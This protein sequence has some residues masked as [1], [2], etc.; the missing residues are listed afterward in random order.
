MSTTHQPPARRP[1]SPETALRGRWV[2]SRAAHYAPGSSR[3]GLA[4]PLPAS[5]PAVIPRLR[6]AVRA[7]AT[8]EG[9]WIPSDRGADAQRPQSALPGAARA[10]RGLDTDARASA[11]D[12]SML[13]EGN[14]QARMRRRVL[15]VD[16]V[17]PTQATQASTPAARGARAQRRGG[18]THVCQEDESAAFS[19]L[20][21]CCRP[22]RAYE[23]GQQQDGRFSGR[24]C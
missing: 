5:A 6:S 22:A 15:V 7:A 19:P 8:A 12:I 4:L 11:A 14:V 2:R 24:R 18:S 13:R 16:G 10:T 1:Q 20:D 21:R 17:S 23:L 3:R 9:C